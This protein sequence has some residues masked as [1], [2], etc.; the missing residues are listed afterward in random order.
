MIG[1]QKQSLGDI[2]CLQFFQ[3]CSEFGE[4]NQRLVISQF[5]CF[6]GRGSRVLFVVWVFIVRFFLASG[7]GCFQI[8]FGMIFGGIDV[9]IVYRML[10]LR[11]VDVT[12]LGYL[13]V[14]L[15]LFKVFCGFGVIILELVQRF[16]CRMRQQVRNLGRQTRCFGAFLCWMFL[17]FFCNKNI[18][19]GV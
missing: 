12:V 9:G 3:E 19:T 15:G 17:Q 2:L 11:I 8:T 13:Q 16:L 10:R 14:F 6:V 18:R 4:G 5:F 1:Y 7:F